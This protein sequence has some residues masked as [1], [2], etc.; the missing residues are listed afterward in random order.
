MQRARLISISTTACTVRGGGGRKPDQSGQHAPR[1]PGASRRPLRRAV[2]APPHLGTEP[3]ATGHVVV[4]NARHVAAQ[5]AP[6][7]LSAVTLDS[8]GAGRRGARHPYL[9]QTDNP[10][11][12]KQTSDRKT[13]DCC[14]AAQAA[15]A[16]VLADRPR[17]ALEQAPEVRPRRGRACVCHER[18]RAAGVTAAIALTSRAV[19]G[20][21]LQGRPSATS[22][23][24]GAS[25]DGV[26]LLTPAVRSVKNAGAKLRRPWLSERTGPMARDHGSTLRL[27]PRARSSIHRVSRS[28][29]TLLPLSQDR[30]VVL[31]APGHSCAFRPL[32]KEDSD[33][34]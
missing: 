27:R 11:G 21:R 17:R 29:R 3:A 23:G 26:G 24:V 12:R 9:T 28:H 1:S 14:N 5:R 34:G 25:R 18:D 4:T 32:Q 2:S 22:A 10:L 6:G 31:R 8:H 20:R 33:R 13:R 7:C 15:V 19:R 16:P 30:A